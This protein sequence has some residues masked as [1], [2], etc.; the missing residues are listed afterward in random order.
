M[1]YRIF[2]VAFLIIVFLSFA[3][4]VNAQ[5]GNSIRGKVRNSL[6]ANLS[7]V[8]VT[9]E[10]GNGAPFSQIAT[11]NEG[12]F[13]FGGLTDTSYVITIS[14]PDYSP[15]TEHVD[16]VNRSGPDNPG[17]TRTVFITL[18]PKD[19]ARSVNGAIFFQAVPKAARDAFELAVRQAKDGKSEDAVASLWEAIGIFPDYFD[20]HFA[21]GREL[22]KANKYRDAIAQLEAARRI[23]PKDDR[24]Y[25]SFGSVLVQQGKFSVAAAVF[26]EAARLNPLNPDYPLMRGKALISLANSIDPSQP[27]DAASRNEILTDAETS[28]KKAYELSGKKLATA[29]LLLAGIYE[30]KGDRRRAADELEQYL[31]A[32]PNDKNAEAIREGIKKLRSP[33]P[34]H[35]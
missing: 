26:A 5:Q 20:A 16:F 23:N 2:S 15:V 25:Y 32:V 34:E 1:N 28:I 7:Q 31:G 11:N 27:K 22:A 10:T 29:H 8:I 18:T 13:F 17:E 35:P 33:Q 19:G 14:V 30:K 9:I 3:S 4:N 24:V 6:G 21:L 12:D